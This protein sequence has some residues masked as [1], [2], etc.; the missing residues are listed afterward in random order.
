MLYHLQDITGQPIVRI[1]DDVTFHSRHAMSLHHNWSESGLGVPTVRRY[2]GKQD[3]YPMGR[4]WHIWI[5]EDRGFIYD[6][7]AVEVVTNPG[8]EPVIDYP[9]QRPTVVKFDF[10]N[11]T[12]LDRKQS[13]YVNWFS[14]LNVQR[15]MKIFTR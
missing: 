6:D 12:E 7:Y 9:H 10:R 8:D 5:W 15:S 4:P 11:K 1:V 3:N 2:E 13:D 14:A